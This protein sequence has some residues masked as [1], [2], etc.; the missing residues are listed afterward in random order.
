MK[1]KLEKRNYEEQPRKIATPNP[2]L[3]SGEQLF[4]AV[5]AVQW[6][7]VELFREEFSPR[8]DTDEPGLLIRAHPCLSVVEF[9][10]LRLAAL[11]FLR[12]LAA[13]LLFGQFGQSSP[14]KVG[15]T[16]VVGS[17][18]VQNTC[19]CFTMKRLQHL[20]IEW[21]KKLKNA[22]NGKIRAVHA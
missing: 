13:F 21:R 9:L 3:L 4:G 15:Q 8:M 2:G 12:S 18:A 16:D 17:V 10:G 11:C 14:V 5:L 22:K 6:F 7:K 19:K 20:S 1:A